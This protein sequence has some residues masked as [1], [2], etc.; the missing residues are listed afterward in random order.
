M[1]DLWDKQMI[2]VN[3]LVATN[4]D[5]MHSLDSIQFPLNK[6]E[7]NWNAVQAQVQTTFLTCAHWLNL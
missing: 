4:P 6:N 3:I 7:S 2:Y 5:K 1:E